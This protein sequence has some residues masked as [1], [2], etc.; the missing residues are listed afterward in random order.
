MIP[1]GA[2][3]LEQIIGMGPFTIAILKYTNGRKT[4]HA[5]GIAV[6]SEKDEPDYKRGSDIA[7]GRALKALEYK[8]RGKGIDKRYMA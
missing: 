8:K 1:E 3:R 5:A 6:K 7:I 4:I 2:Y